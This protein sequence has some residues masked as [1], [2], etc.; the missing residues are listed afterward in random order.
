MKH[1]SDIIIAPVITEKSLRDETVYS[2]F[3]LFISALL[4]VMCIYNIL[5]KATMDLQALMD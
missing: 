2:L 4:L 5:L 3:C 1:Y